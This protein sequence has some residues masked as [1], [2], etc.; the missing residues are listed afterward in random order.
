MVISST[1]KGG[2]ISVPNKG[3]IVT[4]IRTGTTMPSPTAPSIPATGT[5]TATPTS[6]SIGTYTPST[7]AYRY[8]SPTT[9]RT[10][11]GTGGASSGGGGGATPTP[12]P[13][14]STA[15]QMAIA[16]TN[17]Q[18]ILTAQQ[19]LN[20]A[21][22]KSMSGV[23]DTYGKS[24][25]YGGFNLPSSA[26]PYPYPNK[27]TITN[28]KSE[29]YVPSKIDNAIEKGAAF[30]G[31]VSR[32]TQQKVE[33]FLNPN[34][35]K[36]EQELNTKYQISEDATKRANA[37][38][39]SYN[40]IQSSFDKKYNNLIIT[41]SIGQQIF[42]GTEQ[43]YNQ[44]KKDFDN[45]SSQRLEAE[46]YNQIASN[47]QKDLKQR[48]EKYI[49][50]FNPSL[51][52]VGKTTTPKQQAGQLARNVGTS[53]VAGALSLPTALIGLGTSFI[54]HPIKTTEETAKGIINLPATFIKE[55]ST[56]LGTFAGQVVAGKY[57]GEALSGFTKTTKT[58]KIEKINPEITKSYTLQN[59]IKIG[60]DVNGVSKYQV[61][62]KII[63]NRINPKTG[64]TIKTLNTDVVSKVITTQNPEGIITTLA[65]AD[66]ETLRSSRIYDNVLKEGVL[67]SEQKYVELKDISKALTKGT[68]YPNQINPEVFIGT[69]KTYMTKVGEVKTIIN[70]DKIVGNKLLTPEGRIAIDL[71]KI[72]IKTLKTKMPN[73]YSALSNIQI[74][75]LTE[76]YSYG[77]VLTESFLEKG[78][79]KGYKKITGI[80]ISPYI[81]SYR[82]N[83]IKS[84]NLNK[85]LTRTTEANPIEFEIKSLSKPSQIQVQN[86]KSYQEQAVKQIAVAQTQAIGQL[87][88]L[89]QKAKPI[90]SKTITINKKQLLPLGLTTTTKNIGA[91]ISLSN[92]QQ[93][94]LTQQTTK[95]LNNLKYKQAQ[96]LLPKQQ[97]KI[98]TT[99][100]T[101]LALSTRT[102]QVTTTIPI[103]QLVL[104]QPQVVTTPTIQPIVPIPQ[105]LF[106]PPIIPFGKS[107]T[108]QEQPSKPRINLYTPSAN[109]KYAASLGSAIFGISK[110][111]KAKDLEKT[112]KAL[113]SRTYSG[114]EMRPTIQVVPNKPIKQLSNKQ[115]KKS[116]KALKL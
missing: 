21:S 109:P 3:S 57:I 83:V 77:K 45:L 52:E 68:F 1:T 102:A 9:G 116:I 91:L 80:R 103:N 104:Q 64:T 63:T 37:K 47:L 5:Y 48:Q 19:Q 25:L 39:S 79:V 40:D 89:Q 88:E 33:G 13:T 60:E 11:T 100:N 72:N 16:T 38:G 26:T 69:A 115:F 28:Y 51:S 101:N 46:S 110:K 61:V 58:T 23:T 112:L 55:P 49:K 6:T 73:L 42:N 12:S 59:A 18:P 71:N 35:F 106:I 20:L 41:D 81:R 17:A 31:N 10:Y 96:F 94:A 62:A 113:S 85:A 44:Y 43:Q 34:K 14:T 24:N 65:K 105:M 56:T 98:T 54:V 111:V 108:A 4:P 107:L 75:A 67:T 78:K 27:S 15:Q 30:F 29:V 99:I 74:K 53:F 36:T 32:F 87:V 97:N 82:S 84:L 7:G 66:A 76:K 8:T 70:Y 93:K 22:A 86:I 95:T 50:T 114:I 2:T 90:I 92:Q